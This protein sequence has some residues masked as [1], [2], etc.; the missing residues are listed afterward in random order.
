MGESESPSN[1]DISE[2]GILIKNQLEK[3]PNVVEVNFTKKKGKALIKVFVKRKVSKSEI[4]PK[5]LQ[6]YPIEIEEIDELEL[7]KRKSIELK[8]IADFRDED[9]IKKR[10]GIDVFND[11]IPI[12]EHLRL[13]AE[14][15]NVK[16]LDDK[17]LEFFASFAIAA[18][19]NTSRKFHWQKKQ[20]EQRFERSISNMKLAFKL[21][22]IMHNIMFYLGI[23]LILVGIII[24]FDGKSI[25]GLALGGVGLVD[26]ALYLVK[27][28]VEGIHE[29][30]GNLMQLRSTYTSFLLMLKFW[31]PYSHIWLYTEY[32]SDNHFIKAQQVS[33]TYN[34]HTE[35]ALELIQKYCK[36]KEKT[37]E[38]SSTGKDVEDIKKADQEK[39]DEKFREEPRNGS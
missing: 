17:D 6:G 23:A 31:R 24:A 22:I 18:M 2:Q 4:I 30:T 21:S 35:A 32:N 19:E 8:K 12:A 36:V 34:Q 26:I 39:K 14:V 20:A 28:P 9:E 5:N 13:R 10:T 29:S 16:Y 3:L 1:T 11:P 7:L 25:A 33:E 15:L 27:E 37:I 38:K